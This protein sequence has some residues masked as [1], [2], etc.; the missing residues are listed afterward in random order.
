[1]P[2]MN[3]PKTRASNTRFSPTSFL[4]RFAQDEDGSVLVM[5]ILLLITM[6]I[7][8]G[9]AVDFMRFESRRAEIQGVSDRAVLA[10]ASLRQDLDSE[11]VVVDFFEK[12][13]YADAMVGQPIINNTGTSKS[14]QVN[15]EVD[16]NTF[17]LRLAGIDELNAPAASRAIE[18]VGEIEVSLVLD[19]SGSMNNRVV[20]GYEFVREGESGCRRGQWYSGYGKGCWKTVYGERKI[21]LLRTAATNFVN[22]ILEANGDPDDATTPY[23]PIVSISLVNYSAEVNIGDELFD[24]LN[25]NVVASTD[26][27]DEGP[28]FTN[29]T[30]CVEFVS[31][32]FATTEF[33]SARSYDQVEYA[34]VRSGDNTE[35]PVNTTCPWRSYEAIIPL[36]D[37]AK[38]VT[39]A[40]AQLQPTQTTSIHLGMKWGV[41]LLDPS[42]RNVL[43]NVNSIHDD[44][45]GTRPLAYPDESGIKTLKYVVLMTDGENV[46][47]NRLRPSEYDEYEEHVQFQQY[48]LQYWIDKIDN[49]RNYNNFIEQRYSASDADNWLQ[50]ICGAAKD[51]KIVVYSIAM[52]ATDHGEDEMRDCASEPKSRYYHETEGDAIQE[53]FDQIAD[54]ITDLRLN[55]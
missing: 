45:Q 19:I 26:P 41:S 40:I 9:M 4:K 46:A 54:Q 27:D 38:T 16:V 34:D 18:G 21:E 53:I 6:L 10:A 50:D 47:T 12:A 29:P 48:G 42:M 37:E 22:K 24:A 8:G 51:S 2:M 5:T 39:D 7:V 31:T 17:F 13:G 32:E 52:G 43:N 14:V 23:R 44:F 36:A 55:L 15:A 30:R 20:K 49:S 33:N 28:A 1:M 35:S 3:K 11:A 25:V